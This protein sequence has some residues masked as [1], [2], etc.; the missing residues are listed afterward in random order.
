MGALAAT[1]PTHT[2]TA[3]PGA[4]VAASDTIAQSVMGSRGCILQILNGGGSTD[5]I[6][7]SDAGSTPSGN[8]LTGGTIAGSVGA[9]SNK[10][11]L[12]ANGSVNPTTQLVTIT[13][14]F[15]TTVNYKLY[16]I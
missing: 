1:I 16:P 2:G 8:P 6:T 13:H 9:T 5:N 15:T 12:I 11:F 10:V 14:S 4:A 7:I 3:D